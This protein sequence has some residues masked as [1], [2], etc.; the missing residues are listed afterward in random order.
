MVDDYAPLI[1]FGML[2]VFVV[3]PVICFGFKQESKTEES[4]TKSY[5]VIDSDKEE[6]GYLIVSDNPVLIIRNEE[7]ELETLN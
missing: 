7:Y 2:A 4:N 6:V 5:K 3:F 1:L